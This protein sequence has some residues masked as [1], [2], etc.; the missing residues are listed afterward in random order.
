[1]SAPRMLS[2]LLLALQ[3]EV[4]GV[5]PDAHGKKE[6]KA[7]ISLSYVWTYIYPK[8]S[9]APTTRLLATTE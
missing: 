7:Q 8:S 5:V 3:P 6:E 4:A 9:E 2:N 1:M